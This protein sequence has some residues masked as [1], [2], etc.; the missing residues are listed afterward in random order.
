MRFD[1]RSIIAYR[2]SPELI[3]SVD[4]FWMQRLNIFLDATIKHF[5]ERNVLLL[6]IIEKY[7]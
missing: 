5:Y 1:P 2:R 4:R 3:R 6:K 7:F